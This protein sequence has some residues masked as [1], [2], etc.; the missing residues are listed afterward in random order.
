MKRILSFFAAVAVAGLTQAVTI[1]WDSV[2]GAVDLGTKTSS[3]SIAV[4]TSE[5]QANLG[6]GSWTIAAKLTAGSINAYTNNGQKYPSIIG[7][8]TSDTKGDA[9]RFNAACPD[10]N[11]G[12]IG[13]AS[14][15]G[16][17]TITRTEASD[18]ALTSNTTYDFV[19]SFDSQTS[20]VNFYLNDTLYGT[21]SSFTGTVT[22][23]VWGKHGV[24]AENMNLWDN[25]S[26]TY[27]LDLDYVAGMTY[28]EVKASVIPEP[29]AL[30]LLALGAA[31][32]VLRRKAA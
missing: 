11:S 16:K 4:G 25:N 8:G 20:T 19:I 3:G 7:F 29:T 6:N 30:A 31:G 32:L 5:G 23:I 27:S 17:P 10:A 9:Y 1:D 24:D 13:F 22:D 12:N 15:E 28:D 18:V 26:G 14:G 21:L 2:K